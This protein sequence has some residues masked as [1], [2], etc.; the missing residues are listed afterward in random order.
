MKKLILATFVALLTLGM[1][2]CHGNGNDPEKKKAI[3]LTVDSVGQD[4]CYV[5]ITLSDTMAPYYINAMPKSMIVDKTTEE[6]VK[7][8]KKQL[9]L[10]IDASAET[11]D[12]LSYSFFCNKGDAQFCFYSLTP[13]TDYVAYAYYLDTLTGLAIGDVCSL[14]F[15]TN[16]MQILGQRDI[17]MTDVSFHW[18][19]KRGGWSIE[20]SDAQQKYYALISSQDNSPKVGTFSIEN[21]GIYNTYLFV[22]MTE[23][24]KFVDLTVT[25]EPAEGYLYQITIDGLASDGYCY[26][27][28]MDSG[29]P[30]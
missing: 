21:G 18:S 22:D 4:I 29:A 7:N 14:P 28:T 17:Y 8:F 30:D 1:V 23:F 9:D 19:N 20:A 25:I 5:S 6:V 26:H 10:Y 27:I 3:V 11:G 12:R 24:F 13:A 2:S 16:E 15:R